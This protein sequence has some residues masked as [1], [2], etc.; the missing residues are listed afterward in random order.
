MATR[1]VNFCTLPPK[2]FFFFFNKHTISG[3]SLYTVQMLST[4]HC[5][6]KAMSLKIALTLRTVGRR[7]TSNTEEGVKSFWL[8]RA[9]SSAQLL[10]TFFWLLP[11]IQFQIQKKFRPYRYIYILLYVSLTFQPPGGWQIIVLGKL[12]FRSR[13]M[14]VGWSEV[15]WSHS[16]VSNSLRPCGL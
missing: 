6:V 2:L 8:P 14:K 9:R 15:K 13:Y 16:V 7:D 4:T 12:S 1:W 11:S 10:V 5:S 3:F